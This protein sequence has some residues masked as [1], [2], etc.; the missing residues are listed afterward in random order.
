MSAAFRCRLADYDTSTALEKL[1]ALIA[2]AAK[3]GFSTHY[4]N[5]T[6]AWQLELK[7]LERL[8]RETLRRIPASREW[9]LLFEFEIP[10]RGKRP[11]IVLIADDLIF[12]IE[13]KV[14]SASFASA[15]E[16]QTLSYA[17]DLRDF[18]SGSSGRRIIPVL[19][20]TESE[21]VRGSASLGS[22]V[23]DGLV[24]N[25][26]H[27]ADNEGRST[28]G[29]I[30]DIYDQWHDPSV[31]E[32]D[33]YDWDTA[34][35]R[36]APTI[37]EAAESLFA[38]HSVADISHA[39]AQNL[40]VTCNELLCA[41]ERAQNQGRRLIC[42][43]TGI[44][45]A[46]KTLAG[47]NTVHNPAMHAQGRAA[48]VFLSGNGPLVKIVRAA[49]IRDRRRAGMDARAAGRTVTT[50]ID[51]VHRFIHNYGIGGGLK[52]TFDFGRDAAL[53]A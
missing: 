19:V 53:V 13:F 18:H 51:N 50:F 44:P 41:I 16:W 36:P 30:C 49:L 39:F 22:S 14:G 15:D 45:G 48:A 26:Q 33:V 46:G 25:V 1:G 8:T 37:I 20:A 35:Y 42:F 11:D 6:A 7:F 4:T 40:D 3:L 28:A 9:S 17:L 24:F 2:E 38:G 12:V 47:L 21:T 43:V 31:A 10:R 27:S 29:F 52:N 5:Q 32:I 23:A 34:P